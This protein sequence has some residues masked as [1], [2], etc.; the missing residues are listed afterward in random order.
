MPKV[1]SIPPATEEKKYSIER[2]EYTEEVIDALKSLE[3]QAFGEGAFDEW[4]LVPYIRH[5][6]V[7]VMRYMGRIMAYTV[8]MKDWD[9]GDKV[10]FVS[11]VVHDTLQ[12]KGIGT[13][14]IRDCLIMIKEMGYNK[15]ELTVAPDNQRAIK[16]YRDRLGFAETGFNKDEYGKGQD[17]ILMELDL[18]R[19]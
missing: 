18:N 2:A 4:A 17:R 13:S 5:G 9:E 11:T 15:V 1:V 6:N 19:L 8:F 12:G 16:I 14:F 10:Y 7:F 3:K